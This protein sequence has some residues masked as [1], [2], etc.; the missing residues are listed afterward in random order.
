MR[1]INYIALLF[2]LPILAFGQTNELSVFENLVDKT[3]VAEG[4]WENGPAFKQEIEC[5]YDLN[6]T[7]VIVN[8]KGFLDQEQ[9]KFGHRNHGVRQF[10]KTTK[11]IRFWEFDVFGNATQGTVFAEGKNIVYQYKYGEAI[12][13]DMWEYVDDAT[14][15][16]KVGTYTNGVWETLYLN[17]VFKEK[18]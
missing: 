6:G 14:Y 11:A 2:L 4:Q 10:D 18:I 9:T 12:L 8:S 5:R 13:T 17:T 16:F 1:K 15:N 7:V 3:W